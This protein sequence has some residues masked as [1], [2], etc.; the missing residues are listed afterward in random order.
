MEEKKP[1]ITAV[2]SV[3]NFPKLSRFKKQPFIM[4]HPKGP[5]SNGFEYSKG[6]IL[7]G[8]TEKGLKAELNMSL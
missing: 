8:D 5:H 1:C 4:T 7:A 3:S 6:R 2:G